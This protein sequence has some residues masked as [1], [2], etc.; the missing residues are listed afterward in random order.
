MRILFYV[1]LVLALELPAV[2]TVFANCAWVMWAKDESSD[3]KTISKPS[4]TPMGA[5][6]TRQECL[7]G[8]E[9]VY[10]RLS[11]NERRTQ[12]EAVPGLE[13]DISEE[14]YSILRRRPASSWFWLTQLHCFPDTLDPRKG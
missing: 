2:T 9:G 5:M 3:S 8:L 7:A 4:W 13:V 11:E 12:K 10:K 6:D 1:L 14:A